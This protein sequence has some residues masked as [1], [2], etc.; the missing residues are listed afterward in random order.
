M[1][2]FKNSA[3]ERFVSGSFRS[4]FSIGGSRAMEEW[5]K[6][7]IIIAG[8]LTA[9]KSVRATLRVLVPAALMG[10][11]GVALYLK[12]GQQGAGSSAGKG[13]AGSFSGLFKKR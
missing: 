9:I 12:L 6:V 8:S 4:A 10:G 13:A 2:L 1:P 5:Q 3:S 7:L 11:L